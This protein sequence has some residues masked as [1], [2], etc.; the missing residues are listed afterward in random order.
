MTWFCE[1]S[2]NIN[3]NQV[4][5]GDLR[6]VLYGHLPNYKGTIDSVIELGMNAPIKRLNH[7]CAADYDS[8]LGHAFLVQRL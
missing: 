3:D 8:L 4:H 2:N 1:L 7:A 5:G 6:N